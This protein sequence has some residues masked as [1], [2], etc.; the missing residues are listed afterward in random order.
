MFEFVLKQLIYDDFEDFF[1][2]YVDVL[3][4]YIYRVWLIISE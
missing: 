2:L 3:F 1:V 4:V